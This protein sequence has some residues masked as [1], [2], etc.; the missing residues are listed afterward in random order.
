MNNG[1]VYLA[2]KM[3]GLTL[4]EMTEWRKVAK[5]Y[6]KDAGFSILDPTAALSMDNNPTSREIVDNNKYQINHSDLV[7]AEL[8]HDN[9]SL[10]TVGEIIYARSVGKPVIVW[11]GAEQIKSHPWIQ[12]HSTAMFTQLETAIYY[13]IKN[14]SKQ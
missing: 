5:Y 8:D 3:T 14:Y 12:D 7:L 13:I 10:G 11:G 6:L 9:V 1:T 4:L 2:G